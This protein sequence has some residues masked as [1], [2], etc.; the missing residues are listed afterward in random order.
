M[1][2]GQ[3]FLG[4]EDYPHLR[5]GSLQTTGH[6]LEGGA[7]T[8]IKKAWPIRGQAFVQEPISA[9]LTEFLDGAGLFRTRLEFNKRLTQERQN[10]LRRLVGLGQHGRCSLSDDL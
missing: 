2:V 3:Q 5:I 4:R 1:T 10:R 6:R 8:P 7:P 9:G